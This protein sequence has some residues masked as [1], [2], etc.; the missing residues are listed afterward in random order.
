MKVT[1]ANFWKAL[2][3]AAFKFCRKMQHWLWSARILRIWSLFMWGRLARWHLQYKK[4]WLKVIYETAIRQ[5]SFYPIIYF[6]FISNA[7]YIF[8]NML[9]STLSVL[10]QDFFIYNRF[11]KGALLMEC[12]RME[13]VFA[14]MVQ[15]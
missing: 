13:L 3:S 11:F 8:S 9:V 2:S 10:W 14:Q 1:R 7:K 5:V 4:L 15:Q 6:V 12:A